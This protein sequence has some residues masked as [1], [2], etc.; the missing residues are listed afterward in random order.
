MK[1]TIFQKIAE[2]IRT[3]MKRAVPI[4]ASFPPNKFPNIEV[5]MLSIKVRIPEF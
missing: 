4:P 3:G 1:K 5:P 2:A